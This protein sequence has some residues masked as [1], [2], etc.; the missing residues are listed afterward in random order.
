MKYPTPY[1]WNIHDN[2]HK[3]DRSDAEFVRH[4]ANEGKTHQEIADVVGCSRVNVTN[5]IN[6]KYKTL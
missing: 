5:I 2:Q 4:Q 6:N 1:G 3:L